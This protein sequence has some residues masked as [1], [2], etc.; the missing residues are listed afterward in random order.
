MIEKLLNVIGT[1][2]SNQAKSKE[3]AVEGHRIRWVWCS[4]IRSTLQAAV[5]ADIS[6]RYRS[7][8]LVAAGPSTYGADGQSPCVPYGTGCSRSFDHA[9]ASLILSSPMGNRYTRKSCKQPRM[10][11]PI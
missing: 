1:R 4:A 3:Y 11:R 8:R 7:L 9:I 6:V 10:W 2:S 5:A